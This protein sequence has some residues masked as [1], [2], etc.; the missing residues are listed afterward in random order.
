MEGF[1]ADERIRTADLLITNQLLY[2]LSYIGAWKLPH[3]PPAAWIAGSP[4]IHKSTENNRLAQRPYAPGIDYP[5]CTMHSPAPRSLWLALTLSV[6]C[7]TPRLSTPRR[8]PPHPLPTKEI[9]GYVFPQDRV[10]GPEE[11]N[12]RRLT[13]INYAFANI[14]D[15]EIV[16]GFPHD[17]ENFAI[18]NTLKRSNPAL[19]IL[20]SVG[21][22]TW[23]G[24][25]SDAALTPRLP[26]PFYRQRRPLHRAPQAR[27]RRH[28]LGVSRPESAT[29]TSSAPRTNRTTPSCSPSSAI[30][31]TASRPVSA[32]ISTPPSPPAPP[33]NSSNTPRWTKVQHYVDTINL[34]T[35]DFYVG[36][37]ST[38]HDAPLF[39]N[40][41]D[42]K[43]V[44]ADRS[45]TD[46]EQAG[47]SPRKIVLGVPFYGR[48]WGEVPN[49]NHGLFQPGKA[50]KGV[51][52]SYPDLP[53]L[54]ATGFVRYWDAEA[55]A[56]YLYNPHTRIFVT[57]ED[58]Q[59]LAA[60]CKLR[61]RPVTWEASCSGSTSTTPPE[62][63]SR[64]ST[65]DSPQP[66]PHPREATNLMA[67]IAQLGTQTSP[68][69]SEPPRVL[70]IDV[71]RGLT[72]ARHDLRQRSRQRQR[73]SLVD[74]SRSR[75][76]RRHDLR[77]HGLP[78]LPL[79][80]RHGHS[81]RDRA[82]PP[83]GP[84]AAAPLAPRLS[85][86]PS[87][88]SSSDS[89]SP[90]PEQAIPPSSTCAPASGHFSRCSELCSSGWST[91][92]T[93]SRQSLYQALRIAGLVLIVVMFAIFRRTAKD[94]SVTWIQ[95]AYP[96][97]LGLLAFA[98]LTTCIL[99]IPT[100]RWRWAPFAWFV[101]LI[102]FCAF[103]TAKWITFP[104][105][106]SLYLWPFNNG[107]STAIAMAGV[108]HL[109]HLRRTAQSS[110]AHLPLQG[111]LR[112]HL[113]CHHTRR[114]APA[115]TARH[116]QDPRHSHLV[117]LQHRSQHPH[118]HP[119]LL[120]LRRRAPHPLGSLHTL[121]R[122]EHTA[123]LPPA[124]HLVLRT[125]SRS[126]SPGSTLTS[127]GELPGVIRAIVFTAF[128]LAVTT[129]LTRWKIRL[130]L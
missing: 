97:I 49:K 13:R 53:N 113:R 23:S 101:A 57:Y 74:L 50:A 39:R 7:C 84:L 129:L 118:L 30:A 3:R 122:I 5:Q 46:Y 15:G 18:L 21:G 51:H 44:S 24:G 125:L 54:L 85:F 93:E 105:H 92:D 38:G 117:P 114:R 108:S 120:D 32:A 2:Q 109:H 75:Q 102:T 70:S 72:M 55:S 71:F 28:R 43:H 127:S 88:S 10:L 76:S 119:A 100:R 79:H 68:P 4:C 34:M 37:P 96:E 73:S 80:P 48:S 128:I 112:S 52:F 83:Q 87:R 126:A 69:P 66:H 90:T 29:A 11:V 36:G 123:H 12:A 124:R 1:G 41:A 63:F 116:L 42:P 17:A 14:K 60:K 45:V 99:Y 61:H 65:P 59:S 110:L 130:Q 98:Y 26:R 95:T 8:P 6:L 25:F 104:S 86:A 78:R 77:R 47:V 64:P 115:H 58:P 107:S 62:S 22:W 33:L 89:S 56:P 9:I 16:E 94:G 82:A 103:C 121:R 20:V 91:R 106:A 67:T 81:P 35:Y 19:K 40:P 31:S 111:H 27:R